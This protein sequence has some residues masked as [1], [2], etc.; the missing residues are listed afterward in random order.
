VSKVT[1]SH[2]HHPGD[3]RKGFFS[4]QDHRATTSKVTKVEIKQQ[5]EAV[6]NQVRP[7]S[8]SQSTSQESRAHNYA[9]C[10]EWCLAC[11]LSLIIAGTELLP[12]EFCD[13]L[14]IQDG[15]TPAGQQPTRDG[16]GASFNTRHALSC[17]KG[18]LV[19][20]RHNELCD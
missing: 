8:H 14:H 11:G 5:K 17:A 20:I 9:W 18:G 1:N 7:H 16:C 15:H 13:C 10:R 3:E 4:L 19:I 2:I 12:D 6:H